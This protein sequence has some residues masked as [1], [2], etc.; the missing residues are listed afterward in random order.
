MMGPPALAIVTVLIVVLVLLQL[1]GRPKRTRIG[2]FDVRWLWP[3]P[4]AR[5]NKHGRTQDED[6]H[7]A[8]PDNE[9]RPDHDADSA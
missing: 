9:Q 5:P 8:P 7:V 4:R 3:L 1:G 6:T 2:W